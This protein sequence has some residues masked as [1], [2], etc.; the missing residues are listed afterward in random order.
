MIRR[1]STAVL[2]PFNECDGESGSAKSARGQGHARSHRTHARGGGECF[3]S[4]WRARAPIEQR[5]PFHHFGAHRRGLSL[6]RT[7]ACMDMKCVRSRIL[8]LDRVGLS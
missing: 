2:C 4:A 5:R 7:D 6:A 8:L 1:L 3:D